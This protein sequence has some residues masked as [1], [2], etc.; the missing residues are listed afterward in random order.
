MIQTML[1]T[2]KLFIEL[3][4]DKSVSTT[5]GEMVGVYVLLWAL[6]G[7]IVNRDYS[8]VTLTRDG[9][10][11]VVTKLTEKITRPK[12]MEE[13][14][15]RISAFIALTH[16]LGVGHLLA[17]TAFFRQVIYDPLLVDK[18]PWQQV[19]ELLLVYLMD[20][21]SQ[22]IWTMGTI[23]NSGGIDARR[24]RSHTA[25]IE[26]FGANIFRAG[27]G[28]PSTDTSAAT[29]NYNGKDTSTA[30][31]TCIAYN[32]GTKHNDPKHLAPDGTCRFR[33]VCDHWVTG[34]GKNG[35]CLNDAGTAGHS[36]KKCDNPD[37]CLT[38]ATS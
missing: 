22:T 31:Q 20:L 21:D 19:H 37:K 36:R 3:G 18:L 28:S 27:G 11:T 14:S 8:S 5:S 26:H 4:P 10:D 38:A 1:S 23:H 9:S 34:K 12:S 7:K 13:F 16:A 24:K 32:V 17:V 33:H 15:E 35:V 6:A 25:T 30:K 2:L 29:S